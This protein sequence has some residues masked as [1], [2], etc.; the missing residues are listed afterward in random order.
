MIF[1]F[2]G[3]IGIGHGR[4]QNSLAYEGFRELVGLV[5]LDIQ[6]RAPVFVMTSETLHEAGIAVAALMCAAT[7]GVCYIV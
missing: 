3:V 4:K 7:I 5:F 6:K 2:I 1:C